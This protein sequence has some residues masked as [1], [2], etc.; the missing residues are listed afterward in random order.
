MWTHCSHDGTEICWAQLRGLQIVMSTLPYGLS[1]RLHKSSC[2][3]GHLRRRQKGMF[4]T[5]WACTLKGT[6]LTCICRFSAQP[7]VQLV[8]LFV[9]SI[10]KH[11][12]VPMHAVTSSARSFRMATICK[13]GSIMPASIERPPTNT[14]ISC[15]GSE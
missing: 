4:W 12:P 11:M 2:W 10:S 5:M 1:S 3:K 14:S 8:A 6:L 7:R 15:S 13:P 9:P